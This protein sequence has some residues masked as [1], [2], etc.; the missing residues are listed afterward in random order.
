LHDEVPEQVPGEHEQ[1]KI[2]HAWTFRS[3]PVG[4]PACAR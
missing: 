2:T 1:E 3:A 4:C